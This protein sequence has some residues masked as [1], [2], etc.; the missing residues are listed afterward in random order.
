MGHDLR[1]SKVLPGQK[2]RWLVPCTSQ[3]RRGC[4]AIGH[5]ATVSTQSSMKKL[6]H[7]ITK[8]GPKRKLRKVAEEPVSRKGLSIAL[9]S[10]QV[11]LGQGVGRFF[12]EEE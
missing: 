12:S 4:G 1:G 9:M 6:A 7:F 2:T 8:D 11:R 3:S 5:F 10:D